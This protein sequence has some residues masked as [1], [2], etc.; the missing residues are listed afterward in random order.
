MD[1]IAPPLGDGGPDYL[2]PPVTAFR[3]SVRAT[4][5]RAL[6]HFAGGANSRKAIHTPR[7]L[8]ACKNNNFV[9]MKAT[10]GECR[11]FL[12]WAGGKTQLLNDIANNL[13]KEIH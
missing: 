4:R 6:A 3:R 12:K 10:L 5:V 8:F 7:F 2:A 9:A 1:C 11:P 13:P